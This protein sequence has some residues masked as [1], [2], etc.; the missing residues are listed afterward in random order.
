MQ[1]PT[2]ET[3]RLLVRPFVLDDL[4]AIYQILDVELADAHLGTTGLHGREDRQRWLQW[5]V[6]NY[7]ELADLYQPPYGDRAIVLKDTGQVIG[8]IGYVQ[9]LAPFGQLPGFGTEEDVPV[10]SI[11]AFG[12]YWA[13]SP[14]HQ[15][16]G[17]TTEAGRVMVD[18]A[19]TQLELQ[20]IV[21]T[22]EYENV[23]SQGVMRKLG[24]R[25]ERNPRPD[26]VWLQVVGVLD[27]RAGTL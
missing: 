9:C 25:L 5:T 16:H 7:R 14:R 8:A 27:N 26:P 2:L 11:P 24:M 1:M 13:M 18:Y 23:A 6:M 19:F 20:R 22:T 17:Y 12:L 21:A 3:E 15:R 4:E 10:R